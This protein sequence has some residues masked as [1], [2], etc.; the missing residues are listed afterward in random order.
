MVRICQLAD[1]EVVRGDAEDVVAQEG[2]G[3]NRE[4]CS[5]MTLRG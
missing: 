4:D 5:T 1:S 3:M 2:G